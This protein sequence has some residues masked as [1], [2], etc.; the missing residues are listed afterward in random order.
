MLVPTDLSLNATLKLVPSAIA[1]YVKCTM[2]TDLLNRSGNLHKITSRN[3]RVMIC[4][5]L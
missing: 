5:V 3:R 1:I 4:L 2:K